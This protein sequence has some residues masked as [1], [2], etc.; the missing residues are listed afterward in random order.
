MSGKCPERIR[1]VKI[2]EVGQFGDFETGNAIHGRG[3]SI[4]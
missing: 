2:D 4:G 1:S 3:R